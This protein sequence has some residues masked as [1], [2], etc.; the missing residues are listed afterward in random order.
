MKKIKAIFIDSINKEIKEVEFEEELSSYYRLLNC[1]SIAA[2]SFDAKHDVVVDDE[3]LFNPISFFEIETEFAGE[4][5]GNGLIVGVNSNGDWI[6]H[7]LDIEEV[8]K[9]VHFITFIKFHGQVM[10]IRL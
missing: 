6:S 9:K 1:S 10:K 4:Y 2:P 3:G 5:A 7:K 8:K